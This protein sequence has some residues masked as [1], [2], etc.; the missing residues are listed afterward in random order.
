MSGK[1]RKIV[2]TERQQEVLLS[3]VRSSTTAHR[4]VTRGKIILLAFEGKLNQEIGEQVGLN[5]DQVGTWRRR[6]QESFERLV[7]IECREG[8]KALRIAVEDLLSDAPRSG[9][10]V[11]FTAEQITEILAVA[12]E[13]PEDS[14]RPVTHW[15]PKELANEV[16]KRGIVTSISVRQVGRFLKSGRSQTA[17]QSVLVECQSKSRRPRAV[18]A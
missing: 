16:Q 7:A 11:T 4:L 10:P 14:G 17:S 15:T 1:A 3:L 6:W 12:C 13:P 18:P 9:G 5:P 2:I 8:T